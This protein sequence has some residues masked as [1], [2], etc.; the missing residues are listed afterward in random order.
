M[1]GLAV[2]T[3][4]AFRVQYNVAEPRVRETLIKELSAYLRSYEWP[5][6]GPSFIRE[7]QF[8]LLADWLNADTLY[9]S[10]PRHILDHPAYSQIRQMN[11]QAVPFILKRIDK[12][13]N[14]WTVVL[15][16]MTNAQ[17]VRRWHRGKVSQMAED[18]KRWASRVHR[19]KK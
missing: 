16:D 17:P 19:R 15:S 18:W 4:P 5:T 1:S 3:P 7:D 6:V 8:N 14:L 11:E 9:M 10:N 13:P 2:R 12:E